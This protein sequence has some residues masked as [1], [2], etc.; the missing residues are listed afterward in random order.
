[1]KRTITALLL[2]LL[3]FAC[4]CLRWAVWNPA[5]KFDRFGG[6]AERL[7]TGAGVMFLIVAAWV[8]FRRHP[9]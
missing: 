8:Y 5:Y 3:G 9:S 2:V 7:L 4:L 1:M 6:P